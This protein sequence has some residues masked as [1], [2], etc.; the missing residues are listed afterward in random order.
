MDEEDDDGATAVVP[1]STQAAP[2]L[3]WSLDDGEAM[4]VERHSWRMAWA[5]AAVFAALGA[6]CAF[7]IGAVGWVLVRGHEDWRQ[8][9]PVAHRPGEVTATPARKAPAALAAPATVTV[10]ATPPTVTV[11]A[12]PPTVTVEPAPTTVTVPAPAGPL[13][14]PRSSLAPQAA[15]PVGDQRFLDHMRALG[16]VI[17]NRQLLLDNAHEACRLLRQGDSTDQVDQEMA[18]RMATSTSDTL[19]LVSSAMLA[20]PDCY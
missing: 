1:P 20:Y 11:K 17:V 9:P 5:Q 19:Q 2:E 16:Y 15:D 12:T 14:S 6:L 8:S 7:A 13:E 4:P 18:A 10:R 3:A